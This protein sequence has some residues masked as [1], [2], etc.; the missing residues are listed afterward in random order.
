MLRMLFGS[1]GVLALMAGSV[2]AADSTNNPTNKS[3]D[4]AQ[5]KNKHFAATISKVDSQN[6]K[7]TVTIT[8]RDGKQSEKALDIEKD[9][10][11]RDI[12]GKT[13][14][15]SDLKPGMVVRITEVNGKVSKIDEENVATITKV[16]SKAGTVTV[17]MPDESGKLV[18]RVFHL[19]G[20]A[21]YVDSDGNVAV[22]DTFQAGNRV[23]FVEEEGQITALSKTANEKNQTPNL[24]QCS[25]GENTSRK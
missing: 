19:T 17:Q 14:Q 12:H 7:L 22:L 8:G 6:D 9:A 20:N 15:L 24:T 18:T 3:N 1:V 10:A 2:L 4:Q 13:A 16:D 5:R 23:L 21:E 25:G 11:V